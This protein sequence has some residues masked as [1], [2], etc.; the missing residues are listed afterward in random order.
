MFEVDILY[1][2]QRGLFFFGIPLYSHSSLLNFDPGPW[3]TQELKDSA[4]NITNA[5]VPDPTWE[6][7]WKSWYVDMSYD[8]DEEG[9]QYSFHFARRF[10]WHGN[11]PWFHSYVRR[12]RWLRKRVK[13]HATSFNAKNGSMGAAHLLTTDYFTIHSKRDKNPASNLDDV[14]TAR[15]SWMS[16]RSLVDENQIPEEI[17]DVPSMLRGLKLATIDREKV[18]IVKKFIDQGGEEL[19]YLEAVIPEIMS[20]L[21]YQNSRRQLLQYL[22]QVAADA[23]K[24]CDEHEMENEPEDQKETRRINE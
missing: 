5:Q 10:A 1:E 2:N 11:H 9:W 3:M 7:A 21:V 18:D 23:Q 22:K 24:H 16:P 14:P 4:V 6:W 15:S 8:V 12:R 20:F 13:K 19:A 17:K